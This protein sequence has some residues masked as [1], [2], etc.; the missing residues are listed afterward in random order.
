[1]IYSTFLWFSKIYLK[2][3]K[4]YCL[5]WR[6][7]SVLNN[8]WYVD[9][10]ANKYIGK[11]VNVG[12]IMNSVLLTHLWQCNIND[13]H[14]SS[15]QNTPVSDIFWFIYPPFS[16]FPNVGLNWRISFDDWKYVLYRM[17]LTHFKDSWRLE[18]VLLDFAD[19][20]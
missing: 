13:C 8:L 18:Y 19:S 10:H 4:F 1:M 16:S 17:D 3:I 5:L 7:R 14:A 6:Y 12:F 15:S 20:E 9:N 2:R 11:A